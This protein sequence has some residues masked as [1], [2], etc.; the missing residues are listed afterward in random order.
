MMYKAMAIISCIATIGLKECAG[1]PMTEITVPEE[2]NVV[3]GI[4]QSTHR[5]Q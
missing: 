3:V 1:N 2:Q 5:D 4:T